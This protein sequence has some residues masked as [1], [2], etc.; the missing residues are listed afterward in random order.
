M[1]QVSFRERFEAE[2]KKIVNE[3]QEKFIDL[4]VEDNNWNYGEIA[5]KQELFTSYM[6]TQATFAFDQDTFDLP[7][8]R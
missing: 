1:D 7:K 2:C 8:G 4:G 3:T 5:Q 6:N